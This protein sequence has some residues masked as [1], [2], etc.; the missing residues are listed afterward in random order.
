MKIDPK[1]DPKISWS[2]RVLLKRQWPS[3]K[4]G[5]PT[6]YVAW[7]SPNWFPLDHIVEV[8]GA[9]LV[10]KNTCVPSVVDEAFKFT[11]K[12]ALK[13]LPKSAVWLWKSNSVPEVKKR[14]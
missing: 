13:V 12:S 3:P 11:L 8:M 2:L 10:P 9:I 6:T 4:R 14:E 7:Y 5:R 1:I